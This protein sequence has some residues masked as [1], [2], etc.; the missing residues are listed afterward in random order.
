MLQELQELGL[1]EKEARVYLAALE[2]G[3]AT[4]DEIAKQ[5]NIKRSTAYVQ[6][7]S[8]QKQG[9]M[10]S[11]E[12]GKKTYFSPESPENLRR[13]VERQKQNID[14]KQQ[15]LNKI[16]PELSHLF[17]GVGERPR[18]RFFDGKEGI[19]SLREE[20][21]HAKRGVAYVIY[22]F[23]ALASIYSEEELIAFAEKRAAKK[24]PFK[25]IYT[26]EEGKFGY[27]VRTPFTERRFM[28]PER[29]PLSADIFVFDNRVGVMSLKG[30]IFGVLI[31]SEEI[32][33]SIRSIFNVLWNIAEE[34]VS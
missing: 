1:S 33:E 27:P 8:L 3:K 30:K 14:F 17:E 31:E 28:S 12:E 13:T 16:L 26:R 21:F 20:I 24:I 9:L 4:A 34:E 22:S 2:L 6:I 11:Y 25:L 10:S 5:A 32:A 19:T 23:D 29:M 18:V 15:E 7:G